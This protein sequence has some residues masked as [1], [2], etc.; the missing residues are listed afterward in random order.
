MLTG[1]D[2]FVVI[3]GTVSIFSTGPLAYLAI[4]GYR[5]A[6]EL[7]RIQ[8]EL[9]EIQRE[10]RREQRVAVDEIQQTR[11]HVERVEQAASYLSKKR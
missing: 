3:S 5:D 1:I 10:I 9:A 6:R 7:R 2:L 4:R 11:E 8:V